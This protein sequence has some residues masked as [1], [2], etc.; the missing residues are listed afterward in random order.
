[1]SAFKKLLLP[2]IFATAFFSGCATMA[3]ADSWLPEEEAQ[4]RVEGEKL[5]PIQ[6]KLIAA[7]DEYLGRTEGVLKAFGR[8]Y[9]LDCSGFLMAVYYTAGINL[10]KCYSG[11]EGNGVKRLYSCLRD[12]KLIYNAKIPAVGDLIFWDNTYD[13]NEDG[14]FNDYFSHVGMVVDV[15]SDGTITYAHHNYRQGIVLEKMNLFYPH[16][17]EYNSPMRMLGSPPAPNGQSLSSE[18]VRVFARAWKLPKSF[19]R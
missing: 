6:S 10:E 14:L 1:M 19:W 8:S 13:R 18:L 4:H 3:E 7:T 9:Y 12:E 15:A 16:D 5:K 17:R 2:L 11:Y